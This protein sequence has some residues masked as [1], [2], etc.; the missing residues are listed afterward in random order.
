MDALSIF[1]QFSKED[2]RFLPL[3]D[4][5]DACQ[6]T[7][8]GRSSFPYTQRYKDVVWIASNQRTK[9]VAEKM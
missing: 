4:A 3:S 8:R 7:F 9:S 5:G 1:R 6:Q 2:L